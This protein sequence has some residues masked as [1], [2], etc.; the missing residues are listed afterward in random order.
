MWRGVVLQ[1]HSDPFDFTHL[2]EHCC[3]P[4][5]HGQW[6]IEVLVPNKVAVTLRLALARTLSPTLTLT[7]TLTL[8]LTLILTLILTLTLP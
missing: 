2:C 1:V 5:E 7:L 8:A 6:C 3:C 4:L